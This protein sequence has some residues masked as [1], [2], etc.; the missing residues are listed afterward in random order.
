MKTPPALLRTAALSFGHIPG[1]M[2]RAFRFEGFPFRQ[3]VMR[4][5]LG[6]TQGP[7]EG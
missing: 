6:K 5:V 3:S 1:L 2:K 4:L 7:Q